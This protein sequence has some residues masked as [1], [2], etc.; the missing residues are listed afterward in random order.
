MLG[1]GGVLI[2]LKLKAN[3]VFLQRSSSMHYICSY[4]RMGVLNLSVCMLYGMG[5]MVQPPLCVLSESDSQLLI[6]TD[7]RSK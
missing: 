5:T 2:T 3:A 1:E 6:A 4:R 7:R